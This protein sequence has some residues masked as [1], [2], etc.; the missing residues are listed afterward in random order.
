MAIALLQ[1]LGLLWR[2]LL[3]AVGSHWRMD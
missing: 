1:V 2:Y 3:V